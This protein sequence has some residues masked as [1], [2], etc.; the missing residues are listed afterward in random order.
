MKQLD[1]N[2]NLVK[3]NNII[4]YYDFKTKESNRMK[5][6]EN[7]IPNIVETIMTNQGIF[8][9]ADIHILNKKLKDLYDYIQSFGLLNERITPNERNNLFNLVESLRLSIEN[10]RMKEDKE[11]NQSEIDDSPF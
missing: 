7:N 6:D 10:M 11:K 3:D 1:I 2:I 9:L 8:P 5:V 4:E